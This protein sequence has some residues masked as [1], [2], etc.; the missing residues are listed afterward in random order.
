M[1]EGPYTSTSLNSGGHLKV[2]KHPVQIVLVSCLQ[3]QTY[4]L[5]FVILKSLPCNSTNAGQ[6]VAMTVSH[7][8]GYLI[9]AR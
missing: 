1:A 3:V 9:E 6:S 8:R 4:S 5:G 2:L 7:M